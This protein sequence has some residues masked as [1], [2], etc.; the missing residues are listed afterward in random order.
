MD[1]LKTP[2][3]ARANRAVEE[4]ISRRSGLSQPKAQFLDGKW[5]VDRSEIQECCRGVSAGMLYR[6]CF[7]V[8]HVSHLF[9]A[10][11]REVNRI[12]SRHDH[13]PKHAQMVAYDGSPNPFGLLEEVGF[14][15]SA[16]YSIVEADQRQLTLLGEV[17]MARNWCKNNWHLL[18]WYESRPAWLLDLL[19]RLREEIGRCRPEYVL[20]VYDYWWMLISKENTH[21]YEEGDQ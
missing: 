15:L 21:L 16:E 11:P 19:R 8:R 2:T 10:N 4:Y 7:S 18:K 5:W 1:R 17:L 13:K 14:W 9:G 12:L 3:S 6:H 20:K